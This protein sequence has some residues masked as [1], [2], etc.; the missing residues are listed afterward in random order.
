MRKCALPAHAALELGMVGEI[1]GHYRVKERLGAG[2]MA[3]VWKA[4]DV[5]LGREVALK[6]P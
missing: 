4:T 5:Q 2:G 3:V 1:V 6:L